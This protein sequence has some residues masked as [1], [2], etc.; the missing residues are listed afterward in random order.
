MKGLKR[1][2]LPRSAA[3]YTPALLSS[4]LRGRRGWG[5][6]GRDISDAP[7]HFDEDVRHSG[8]GDGERRPYRV[9]AR[10]LATSLRPQ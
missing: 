9:Y 2:N 5:E 7:A 4:R 1:L 6:G 3:L 8:D 10:I